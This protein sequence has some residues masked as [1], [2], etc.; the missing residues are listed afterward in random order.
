MSGI[1]ALYCA[2]LICSALVAALGCLAMLI[3]LFVEAGGEGGAG[4]GGEKLSPQ[5]RRPALK[6]GRRDGRKSVK[7]FARAATAKRA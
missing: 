3:D 1:E 6:G 5:K 4:A 2:F 7:I